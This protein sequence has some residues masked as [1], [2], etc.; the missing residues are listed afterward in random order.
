MVKASTILLQRSDVQ[1][2]GRRTGIIYFAAGLE[3]LA[4]GSLQIP[5]IEI[6]GFCPITKWGLSGVRVAKKPFKNRIFPK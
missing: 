3:H 2:V 1:C 4:Q 5:F 6:M